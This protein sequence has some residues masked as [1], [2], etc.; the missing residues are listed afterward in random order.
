MKKI[1]LTLIAVAATAVAASAQVGDVWAGAQM[2]Y[3]SK[4]SMVGLG[5]QVQVEVV[6][7]LRV[8]PEF[9]YYFKNDGLKD[10][11]VNLNLHYL[12]NSGV[13]GFYIYPIAGFTYARF[14]EDM[15]YGGVNNTNRFGANIGCGAEYRISSSPLSFF[16]EE[17]VQILKD[18]TQSVTSMGIKY[19]F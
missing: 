19:K 15:P 7:K 12:I 3:G 16:T 18:W 4:N 11:N 5:A 1:I 6:N 13:E 2:N 17:R 10:Y 14:S 9:I 8:A